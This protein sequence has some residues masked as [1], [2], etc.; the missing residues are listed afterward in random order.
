MMIRFKWGPLA[1]SG[2]WWIHPRRSVVQIVNGDIEIG[3]YVL[4]NLGWTWHQ[5]GDG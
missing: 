4:S 1:N 3:R 5:Q 2:P